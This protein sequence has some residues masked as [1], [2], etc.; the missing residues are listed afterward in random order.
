MLPRRQFL[1]VG[2][3]LAAGPAAP[4]I[5]RARAAPGQT[6]RIGYILPLGSQVG[7]GATAFADEVAKRS[8][9]RITVQ[10]FP[11]ATLGADVEL[12]KGVQLGSIDLVCSTGLGLSS[13][14]PE[15]SELNIPFLFNSIAH[16][17]AVLDGPM[18]EAF[19][20]Q[21]AAKDLVMLDWSESGLRHMTNSKHPIVTPDDMK[22]L[23]MRMPP[24]DVMT[25]G[26]RALGAEPASLPLPQL[27]EALRARQI[28]WTGKPD[29]H[30]PR[31]Q[32]RSGAEVPHAQR[33]RLRSRGIPDVAD[34]FDELSAEDKT[35][36]ID[37]AK[38]G[39]QAARKFA[40]ELEAAGVQALRQAG[41]TVQGEIDR[42]RFASA[43]QAVMPEFEQ[44]FGRE[45]DRRDQKGRLS[46]CRV[47]HR[48]SRRQPP[49]AVHIVDAQARIWW[50][51]CCPR[52][53]GGVGAGGVAR[54]GVSPRGGRTSEPGQRPGERLDRSRVAGRRRPCSRRA[55]RAVGDHGR[56]EGGARQPDPA[57]SDS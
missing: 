3:A 50:L 20:K 22:G 23:T 54:H 32:V 30:D 7:A 38:V 53:A 8:G 6:L 57:R 55:I 4:A 14:P 36:F 29:R 10:Q 52:F 13:V 16:A 47:R 27:F 21:F 46:E 1:A 28:R 33:T 35:T 31:S 43:M 37:A 9:G 25:K 49:F 39:K 44:R 45:L 15:A 56:S 5:R 51:R 19:R 26:F 41:M 17:H 18:G 34:V 42:Q 2:T 24:S 12:L 40:T 48:D 11:D